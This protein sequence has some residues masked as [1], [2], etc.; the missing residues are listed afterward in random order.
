MAAPTYRPPCAG[1][2]RE[3]KGEAAL[4]SVTRDQEAPGP[5]ANSSTA[6]SASLGVPLQAMPN[7]ERP[8]AV[9]GPYQILHDAAVG[10]VVERGP[11]AVDH[12]GPAPVHAGHAVGPGVVDDRQHEEVVLVVRRDLEAVPTPAEVTGTDQQ[13][14]GI[15]DARLGATGPATA[16]CWCS[17]AADVTSVPPAKVVA[18]TTDR[19]A[20]RAR[21]EAPFRRAVCAGPGLCASAGGRK[22]R[23]YPSP[24]P[25]PGAAWEVKGPYPRWRRGPRS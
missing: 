11:A 12:Q 16:A 2:L 3:G 22:N 7:V 24:R 9:T 15:A 25:A 8:V 5:A 6:K 13:R 21:R 10:A 17:L 1:T 14:A 20:A 4:P 19:L 23:P 18:I